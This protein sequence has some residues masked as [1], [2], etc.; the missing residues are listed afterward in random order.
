M[1]EFP[2][3][4][5]WYLQKKPTLSIQDVALWQML[6]PHPQRTKTP[7]VLRVALWN[8]HVRDVP[9]PD[10]SMTAG[11]VIRIICATEIHNPPYDET[12]LC[13]D[14]HP[15]APF[16]SMP[17]T[18]DRSPFSA[19]RQMS[20]APPSCVTAAEELAAGERLG[21]EFSDGMVGVRRIFHRRRDPSL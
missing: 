6:P 21:C 15:V 1:S 17:W 16:R 5:K 8:G 12:R 4:E 19:R 2:G 14:G 20:V 18:A 3:L 7:A 9:V 11:D 13:V 10:R